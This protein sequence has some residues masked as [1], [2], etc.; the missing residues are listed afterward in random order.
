MPCPFEERVG[1]GREIWNI[2]KGTSNTKGTVVSV[3]GGFNKA[4]VF[5]VTIK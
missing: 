5:C 1:K 3:F 4:S 2:L